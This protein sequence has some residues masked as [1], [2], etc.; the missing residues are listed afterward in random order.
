MMAAIQL[1]R[2][3]ATLPERPS[4]LHKCANPAC[5]SLFRSLSRGKLFLLDTDNSAAAASGN[6]T[7]DSQRAVRAPDGALLVMR[8]LFLAPHPDIRTRAR[9]GYSSASRQEYSRACLASQAGAAG[10]ENVSGGVERGL[11]NHFRTPLCAICG[12]ERSRE[13]APFPDRRK[14]LGGQ[15]DDSAMERAHGLAGRAFKSPA[16]STMSRNW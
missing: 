9:N 1:I 3:T 4:V 16:A 8:W 14:Q 5:P 10:R 13:P 15:A 7:C 6:R 12:E 11:M 2:L